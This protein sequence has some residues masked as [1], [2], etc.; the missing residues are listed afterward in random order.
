MWPGWPPRCCRYEKVLCVKHHS[1]EFSFHTRLTISNGKVPSGSTWL[2]S[3]ETELAVSETCDDLEVENAESSS[4]K[5]PTGNIT[6][7]N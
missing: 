7:G 5:N 6:Y 2:F 4:D 1:T 3:S